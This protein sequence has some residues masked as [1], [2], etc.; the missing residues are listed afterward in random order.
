MESSKKFKTSTILLII[1]ILLS[2]VF[3]ND[4]YCGSNIWYYPYIIE[5]ITIGR[6]DSENCIE[7]KKSSNYF[8]I[9][10]ML[11][12]TSQYNY[13]NIKLAYIKG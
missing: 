10:T 3:K 9:N 12:N 5:K 13:N 8:K 1:L 4:W 6:Q 7:I 2:I 11:E